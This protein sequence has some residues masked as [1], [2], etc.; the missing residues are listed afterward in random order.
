MYTVREFEEKNVDTILAAL[1]SLVTVG[2]ATGTLN[3]L[4]VIAQGS[5]A[6]TRIGRKITMTKFMVNFFIAKNPGGTGSSPVRLIVVYDKQSNALTPS[7]ADILE[8]DDM[9]AHPNRGNAE[10]FHFL[11]DKVVDYAEQGPACNHHR[12][13]CNVNLPVIYNGSPLGN[14]AS[15]TTGAVWL[16]SYS[17]GTFVTQPP[18]IEFSSRICFIDQ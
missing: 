14:I 16:L 3:Q 8:I 11:M 1:T 6:N 5:T 17:L 15:I 9:S 4:N 2:S 18:Y 12:F 13:A 7:A 10:R